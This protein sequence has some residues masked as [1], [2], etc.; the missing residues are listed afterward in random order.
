MEL[1]LAR[2]DLG[3]LLDNAMT[4]VRERA[5][6]ARPGA[7]AR[8]GRRRRRM[9]RRRAQGQAGADQP[10]FQRR[11]VH[12]GGRH[13]DACAR[14]RSDGS[15][16]IAVSDT[17]VGIAPSRPGAGVRGVPPGERR[18]SAQVR[19]HRARACRWRGA[20]SSCTAAR[21]ASRAARARAR[22]SPSRFRK[23]HWRPRNGVCWPRRSR[24]SGSIGRHRERI[25][26][27]LPWVVRNR[28]GQPWSEPARTRR[29]STTG[30]NARSPEPACQ[31]SVSHLNTSRRA[32]ARRGVH[33]HPVHRRRQLGLR[34]AGRAG[35]GRRSVDIAMNFAA[36]LLV[37]I[38]QGVPIVLLAGVH[39]GCF[40][41]FA[42]E[43]VR[44]IEDL[45]GKTVAILSRGS[46]QHVFLA[47]IATSVGLVPR[48][49]HRLGRIHAG[50]Q[51]A[52][53]RRGQA[54][55]LPRLSTPTRRNCAPA[56]SATS[57]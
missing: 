50:R 16:E 38:D 39:S 20:S 26:A 19:R 52:A 46:A 15:V 30:N 36:P 47:S 14:R 55:C 5:S 21:S 57:C 8:R 41:L 10:A 13:G 18:L 23:W 48:P 9:G 43:R 54:R 24:D 3:L 28:G 33:G 1:D 40:E 56:G 31:S 44:S 29:R 37:A 45:K 42:G 34:R 27:R 51:Q 2:F 7:R 11:Q 22:R 25:Q 6:A 4:L 49:R 17:G 53:A 35:D 12:A 32:A